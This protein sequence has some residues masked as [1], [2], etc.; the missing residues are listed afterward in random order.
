MAKKYTT[1]IHFSQKGCLYER[2]I[3]AIDCAGNRGGTPMDLWTEVHHNLENRNPEDDNQYQDS[4]KTFGDL[5]QNLF[6]NPTSDPTNDDEERDVN[7]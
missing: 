2:R 6:A 7:Q 4:K 5:S 3:R 1:K